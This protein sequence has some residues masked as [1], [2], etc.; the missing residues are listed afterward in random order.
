MAFQSVPKFAM[1]NKYMMARLPAAWWD[2]GVAAV[3]NV[4]IHEFCGGDA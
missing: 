1:P 4:Y 2:G 3:S